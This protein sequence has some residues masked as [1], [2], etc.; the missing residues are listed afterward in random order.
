[1]MKM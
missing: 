1:M